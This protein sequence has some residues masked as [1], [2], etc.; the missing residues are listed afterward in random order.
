MFEIQIPDADITTGSVQ[1]SW[2]V[3]PD[4]AEVI[5]KSYGK[6]PYVILVMAP[7]GDAYNLY[8]EVRVVAPLRDL[9]AYL[10]FKYSGKHKIYAFIEHTGALVNMKFLS[11]VG[12]RYEFSVLKYDGSELSH[13]EQFSTSLEVDIPNTAFAK[14]PS[15][16]EKAWV[17]MLFQHDRVADQCHFRRRRIFAYTIQPIIMLGNMLIRLM[18]AVM[19]LLIGAKK[20]TIQPLL[21]PLEMG[22]VH[23]FQSLEGGSIFIRNTKED[24]IHD[25]TG[26]KKFLKDYCF[27]PFM[28]IIAITLAIIAVFVPFLFLVIPLAG[29]LLLMVKAIV[30]LVFMMKGRSNLSLDKGEPLTDADFELLTCKSGRQP[31]DFD[32]LPSRKKTIK[33]RYQN[34]KAKVCRP[35]AG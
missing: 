15:D 35:F 24:P 12:Y 7:V 10:P 6:N 23:S 8:K 32:R 9:I 18:F 19:A 2:C 20:F 28:P 29:L 4:A 22:I 13:N 3:S 30:S 27:F 5:A 25:P 31:F 33:L 11:K 26:F 14:E 1:V 16:L 21:Q 34:L 17:N